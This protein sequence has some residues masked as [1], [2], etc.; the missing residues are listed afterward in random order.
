[1]SFMRVKF[2]ITFFNINKKSTTLIWISLIIY[3][4]YIITTSNLK[5]ARYIYSERMVIGKIVGVSSC[6]QNKRIAT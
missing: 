4:A 2:E 6:M 5:P 1:M 3:L